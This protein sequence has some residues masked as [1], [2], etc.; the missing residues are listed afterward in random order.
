MIN[1]I[2]KE[3]S[4]VVGDIIEEN[5]QFILLFI[6]SHHVDSLDSLFAF[7]SLFYLFDFC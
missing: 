7:F 4:I 2:M 1:A 3:K 6:G 5:I